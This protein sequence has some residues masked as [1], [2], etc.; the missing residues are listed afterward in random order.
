MEIEDP[1]AMRLAS[2]LHNA[3]CTVVKVIDGEVRLHS[4]N[5]VPH[6]TPELRTYR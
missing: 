4:F 5:G 1:R 2:V 6:L 3:S